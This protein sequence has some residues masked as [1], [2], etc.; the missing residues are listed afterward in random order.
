VKGK[1]ADSVIL[2]IYKEWE[3]FAPEK[4]I[5]A[6]QVYI[7][8]PKYHDKKENYCYGIMRNATS[9]EVA[10]QKGAK[11]DGRDQ[12]N[13]DDLSLNPDEIFRKDK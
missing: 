10:G 12:F 5:Y 8:N 1:I 7:N 3:K 13:Y 9:E 2:G 6:L 4:V 11:K